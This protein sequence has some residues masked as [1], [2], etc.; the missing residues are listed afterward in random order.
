MT[1]QDIIKKVLSDFQENIGDITYRPYKGETYNFL[2]VDAWSDIETINDMIGEELVKIN[3]TTQ[4]EFDKWKTIQYRQ[5]FLDQVGLEFGFADEYIVCDYCYQV[6]P[7][8]KNYASNYITFDD[9]D[10]MCGDCIEEHTDIYLDWILENP[11]ERAN[12]FLSDDTLK[13]FGYQKI[14]D[15]WETGYH[16][17]SDNPED[18]YNA[19]SKQY[20]KVIFS[21]TSNN[22]FA[23]EFVAFVKDKKGEN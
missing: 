14:S 12:L 2:I 10:Y 6:V 7:R 17:V 20:E 18:I 15:E 8:T 19:L 23:T 11:I 5:H 22:P 4:A 13:K 21:I 16:G 1:H 9:G 3:E